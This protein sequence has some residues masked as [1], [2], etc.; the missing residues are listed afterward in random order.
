MIDVSV[1]CDN[2]EAPTLCSHLNDILNGDEGAFISFDEQMSIRY[3]GTNAVGVLGLTAEAIT[4]PSNLVRLLNRSPYLD[5]DAIQRLLE[6]V[7]DIIAANDDNRRSVDIVTRDGARTLNFRIS[8]IATESWVARCVDVTERRAEER[9]AAESA[10]LDPL[11]GLPNR[12]LFAAQIASSFASLGPNRAFWMMLIDLDRFKTVNDTLG[13]PIGDTLLKLVTK[14]LRSTVGRADVVARLGGDEFAVLVPG[15][16]SVPEVTKLAQR[17]INMLGRPYL[18]DGHVIHIGASIG[19][20]GAPLDAKDEDQLFRT[21]DLAMY[22]SKKGGRNTLSF[23]E[24]SMDQIALERRALEIDLRKVIALRQ[25][26]LHYQPQIDLEKNAIVGFEALIR[27][28]HPERGLVM[29][30]DFIPLAEE[31]GLIVSIGEWVLRE[32]CLEAIRWP[33]SMTVAVNVSPYQF[34]N[35]AA[36]V[37]AVS[38]A[39]SVSGLPGKRLE[40]EI[41]ESVLLRNEEVVLAAL[42]EL[43][44]LGVRIAMDDFGTGYSSLSQ[45]NSFPFD[46]IKIDQSFVNGAGDNTSNN[47]IVRAI[48][49]LGVSLGMSTIAEGVETS[50]DLERIR[51]NGC[52]SVQGYLFSKPISTADITGLIATFAGRKTLTNQ[53]A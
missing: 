40:I 6:L 19:I 11:T 29:P 12:R 23:F 13:H 10:T 16:D 2:S 37:A 44:A 41:T 28:Q 42:H 47:A 3:V 39:L 20:A 1:F 4:D 50:E 24:P 49:A 5:V 26:E 43:R 48:S 21:A 14:R 7:R 22:A 51:A 36:L 9:E 31:I 17:L 30:C 46:K 8:R 27:W 18:I 32:A 35:S 52:T 53:A 45:L 38:K 34:E 33:E 15:T 25:L